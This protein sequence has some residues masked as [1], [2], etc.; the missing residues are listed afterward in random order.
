MRVLRS[1][2]AGFEEKRIWLGASRAGFAVVFDVSFGCFGCVMGCVLVMAVGQVGVM[3]GYFVLTCFV[4]LSGFFVMTCRVFVM[5]GC[6][7]MMFCC[8]L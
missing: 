1:N 5:L 2:R 8:L 3:A 7:V 6:F 4:M